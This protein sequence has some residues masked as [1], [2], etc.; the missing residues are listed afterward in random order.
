[1]VAGVVFVV[2]GVFSLGCAWIVR[3][4]WAGPIGLLLGLSA[5]GAGVWQVVASA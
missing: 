3:D 5:L 2:L 4:L 1:M